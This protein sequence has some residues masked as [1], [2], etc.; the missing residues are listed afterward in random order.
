MRRSTEEIEALVLKGLSGDRRHELQ[1]ENW[2]RHSRRKRN[3]TK[4][5]DEEA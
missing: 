2:R 1:C 3:R 5:Q 4:R